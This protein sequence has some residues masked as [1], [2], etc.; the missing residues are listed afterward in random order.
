MLNKK[1][2]LEADLTVSVIDGEE[3]GKKGVLN[4]FQGVSEEERGGERCVTRL[5]GCQFGF[6]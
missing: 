1:A 5:Q 4:P 3:A 6:L 2:G